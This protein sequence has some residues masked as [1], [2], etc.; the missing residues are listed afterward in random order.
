[1]S[2]IVQNKVRCLCPPPWPY[3]N[4]YTNPSPF[5][6]HIPVDFFW[7]ITQPWHYFLSLA[8]LSLRWR[9]TL[10]MEAFGVTLCPF[11]CPSHHCKQVP[12]GQYRVTSGTYKG[13]VKSKQA[14]CKYCPLRK[15]REG[16]STVS[17]PTCFWCSIH[18]VAIC[19]K[20]NCWERHLAEVTRNHNEGLGI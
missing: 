7:T 9:T 13:A 5:P 14:R 19:R 4:T 3:L 6:G 20:H 16:E 11:L 18:E 2:C 15:R 10:C 1:M 12:L 8:A 17:P